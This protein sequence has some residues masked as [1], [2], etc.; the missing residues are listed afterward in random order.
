MITFVVKKA[1]S[2]LIMKSGFKEINKEFIGELN[3]PN[4]EVLNS[5]I[6]INLRNLDLERA[7]ALGNTD[8]IKVRIYFEDDK[9]KLF[10]ETTIW[11][12]TDERIILKKGLTIPNQRILKVQ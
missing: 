5:D 6:E 10:V 12:V 2:T 11:G 4:K 1:S 9:D 3:F 8:Q 7:V